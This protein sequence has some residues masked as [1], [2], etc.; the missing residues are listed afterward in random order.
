M[1]AFCADTTRKLEAAVTDQ[2]AGQPTGSLLPCLARGGKPSR[3]LGLTVAVAEEVVPAATAP[4]AAPAAAA[5]VIVVVVAAAVV[6]PASCTP[7]HNRLRPGLCLALIVTRI[8]RP[9]RRRGG[10][11]PAGH[12][13]VAGIARRALPQAL[14][15]RAGRTPLLELPRGGGGRQQGD[16]QHAQH[17]ALP[18]RKPGARPRSLG[19]RALA[20]PARA[21]P[22]SAP[23]SAL[24]RPRRGPGP[25]PAV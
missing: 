5:V 13:T 12:P 16:R 4:A 6:A 22:F 25:L 11:A 10:A 21:L 2:G 14:T 20:A 3:S 8:R 23:A 9:A 7:A 18:H 17:R 19:R 24:G 15:T 1:L